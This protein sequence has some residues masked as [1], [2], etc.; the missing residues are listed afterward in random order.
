MTKFSHFRV[1]SQPVSSPTIFITKI[2]L[3]KKS[4]NAFERMRSVLSGRMPDRVPFF[5]TIYIDHACLASGWRFE[6]ALVNPAL[7]PVAMLTAA[8]RY[9]TDAVRFCLGPENEWYR[10]KIVREENGVLRQYDQKSGRA[11]GFYDVAGGGKFIA[12]NPAPP[13]TC[14]AEAKQIAVA[15]AVVYLEQGCLDAVREQVIVAHRHQLFTVGM[16]SAQTLNFMVEQMGGS[17]A[18]LLCLLD[19]PELACVLI[20]KAVAISI[21]KIRAFLAVGVDCIYIGDSYASGSVISSALYERFCVPAYRTVAAEVHHLGAF[22]YKHCCGN[23]N[24]FLASLP[25]IGIDAMDGIDP[26]SG[27]SVKYTKAVVGDKITLM[28]GIS[29][30]TL[31]NG[32]TEQVF[33]EAAQCVADGKPG[34]RY[35]LG[36]AC[37]VPRNTPPENMLAARRAA[38]DLGGYPPGSM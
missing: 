35:V 17:E 20:D 23:Y 3:E 1:F 14:L 7:G 31:L 11:E 27:M 29:C 26:T 9:G 12:F 2:F 5:P 13:I 38:V 21:E 25:S 34:G 22:C 4:M 37:A 28:G 10:K 8:L 15:P 24:P 18:A 33:A 30:L 36:S 19:D 16:V 32:T 6:D